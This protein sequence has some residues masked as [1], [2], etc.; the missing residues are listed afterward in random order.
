MPA[1]VKGR[2]AQAGPVQVVG[3][4]VANRPTL[5]PVWTGIDALMSSAIAWS[6]RQRVEP[7]VAV[8]HGLDRDTELVEHGE[9]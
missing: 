8:A 4:T 9:E 1:G 2:A 5:G 7:A 3:A 6:D